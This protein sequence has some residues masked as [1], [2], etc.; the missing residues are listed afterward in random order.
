[1]INKTDIKK[2]CDVLVSY[3]INQTATDNIVNE[4]R[5]A[6]NSLVIVFSPSEQKAWNQCTRRR[7]MLPYVDAYFAIY[8]PSHP[9]RKKLL[10]MLAILETQPEYVKFFIPTT[11]SRFNIF[12]T[13][14][15][16][17]ASVMKAPIGR[18][19]LWTI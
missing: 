13:T 12:M 9:F 4:Y 19:L 17:V 7:W 5:Y 1:M 3:L 15:R 10:L 2:E 14:I 11:S 8:K 6:I 16:A 18:I